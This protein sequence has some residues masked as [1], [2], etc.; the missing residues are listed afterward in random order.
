MSESIQVPSPTKAE[1]VDHLRLL[2]RLLNFEDLELTE[3]MRLR[4]YCIADI[5]EGKRNGSV[6]KFS[7]VTLELP[8]GHRPT[9]LK[10][11]GSD[12]LRDTIRSHRLAA[13]NITLS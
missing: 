5:I 4:V 6:G 7:L 9:S 2:A 11:G 12:A 1:A 8:L 13:S 10:A 3:E